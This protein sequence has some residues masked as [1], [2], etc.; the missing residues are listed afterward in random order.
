MSNAH[1]GDRRAWLQG[2]SMECAE[3]AELQQ[4][5]RLILLGAPGV[6]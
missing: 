6:G 1:N 5:W 2:L 3:A 4:P